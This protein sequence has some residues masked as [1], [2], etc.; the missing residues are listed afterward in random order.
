MKTNRRKIAGTLEGQ[1]CPS[2]MKLN[3]VKLPQLM[4]VSVWDFFEEPQIRKI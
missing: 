2:T 4:V 1:K 3:T